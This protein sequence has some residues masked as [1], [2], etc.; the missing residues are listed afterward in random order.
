MNRSAKLP[1]FITRK[2]HTPLMACTFLKPPTKKYTGWG[3]K[4]KEVHRSGMVVHTFNPIIGRQMQVALYKF[5]AN[6]L[7]IVSFRTPRVTKQDTVSKQA[8]KKRNT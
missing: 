2:P 8:N 6:L 3:K 1:Q 4:K 7:Y 5:E